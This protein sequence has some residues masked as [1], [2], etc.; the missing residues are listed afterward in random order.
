MLQRKSILWH[1]RKTFGIWTRIS[2]HFL[3]SNILSFYKYLLGH[4]LWRLFK[5]IRTYI[6][7]I[8]LMKHWFC[9]TFSLNWSSGECYKRTCT[10]ARILIL[11][12][13]IFPFSEGIAHCLNNV[14]LSKFTQGY[15]PSICHLVKGGVGAL[16]HH[17]QKVLVEPYS[18]KLE[19]SFT[20]RDWEK[21]IQKTPSS[22]ELIKH[23]AINTY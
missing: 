21:F 16:N 18:I 4:E 10:T 20:D 23:N 1:F 6:L 17:G 12:L 5:R 22:Y 3:Q 8:K 13:H 14:H 9:V 11:L 15:V 7:F 2:M 19:E